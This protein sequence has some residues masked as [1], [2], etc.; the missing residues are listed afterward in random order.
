[1]RPIFGHELELFLFKK[2]KGCGERCS[3]H[4][5]IVC[6]LASSSFIDAFS[7]MQT[8]EVGRFES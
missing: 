5:S 2:S 6:G 3:D 1:M 8:K 7:A 4:P